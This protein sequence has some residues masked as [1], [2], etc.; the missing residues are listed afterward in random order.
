MAVSAITLIALIFSVLVVIAAPCIPLFLGKRKGDKKLTGFLS[1]ILWFIIVFVVL[2]LLWSLL[3]MDNAITKFLGSDDTVSMIRQTI[4]YVFYA[5]IETAAFIFVCRRFVKKGEETPYKALRF[6]G[7]Y[8]VPETIY[9]LVY[10]VLPL[11]VILTNGKSEFHF[12]ES[13]T[14]STI[15]SAG[16][17]AYL[18]KA[19]WRVLNLIIYSVSMYLVFTGVRYDAKW[20]YFIAPILNLGLDLPYTYTAINS[21]KWTADKVTVVNVY[22]KSD[23]LACILMT[24]TVI[25]ALIICRVVYKN[26][27]MPEE[28][29]A[30]IKAKK[31]A[32]RDKRAEKK[33][34]RKAAKSEKKQAKY[35]EATSNEQEKEM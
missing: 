13:F 14:L 5:V 32:K 12:I 20:F 30:A 11:I 1:G 19:F 22:W 9:I 6:A 8:A 31:E 24:L 15:S 21:R 29:K 3:D 10:L 4:M 16:A 23:R 34:E 7:G 18:F 33:A 35:T 27:Y 17:S 2:T 25:I 28:K 26:Y